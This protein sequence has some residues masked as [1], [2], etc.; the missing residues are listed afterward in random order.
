MQDYTLQDL[1]DGVRQV[2]ADDKAM[3]SS[4]VTAPLIAEL[5]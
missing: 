3:G 1:K 4:R 5:P 2:V